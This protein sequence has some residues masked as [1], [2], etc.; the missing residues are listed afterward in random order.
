MRLST[1]GAART[2]GEIS[3]TE[4][5]R[6]ACQSLQ[7]MCAHIRVTFEKAWDEF[8]AQ[9]PPPEPLAGREPTP[10][11]AASAEPMTVE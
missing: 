8:E 3:A 2:A 1:G 7:D 6:Q 10:G 4:A 5:L 11:R 9:Q